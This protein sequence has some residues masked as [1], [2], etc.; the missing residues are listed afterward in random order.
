MAHRADRSMTRRRFLSTG[1]MGASVGVSHG[2]AQTQEKTALIAI[3]LDC[4]MSMHYPTW[5]QM[6][7]NYKKGDLDEPTKQYAVGAAR[8]VAAAG[9]KMHF[10]V[11]GRVFEQPDISWLQEIVKLG[12]GVGN[13]TYDHVNEIGRARLNSSHSSIS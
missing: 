10:F 4:E 2:F 9:G 6:E 7:W 11:V 1:A 13:H 8:R 5:D 3:T 12:H